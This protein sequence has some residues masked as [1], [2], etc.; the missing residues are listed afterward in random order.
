MLLR[1]LSPAM[2]KIIWEFRIPIFTRKDLNLHDNNQRSLQPSL[3]AHFRPELVR[4]VFAN[5][6]D[7][8]SDAMVT[9]KDSSPYSQNAGKL[10]CRG[11][12]SCGTAD[13]FPQAIAGLSDVQQTGKLGWRTEIAG[14]TANGKLRPL[15]IW[16][17]LAL[18]PIVHEP[19]PWQC[20]SVEPSLVKFPS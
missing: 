2:V 1:P 7:N 9:S 18:I 13:P 5:H 15:R 14:R 8:F 3:F 11:K 20:R 12:T 4:A 17:Y 16:K 6:R 19:L 10:T